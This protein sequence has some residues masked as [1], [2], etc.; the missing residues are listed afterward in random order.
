MV[1]KIRNTFRNGDHKTKVYLGIALC[2]IAATI[3]CVIAAAFLKSFVVL[4]G[5]AVFLLISFFVFRGVSFSVLHGNGNGQ[6]SD[7]FDRI[8]KEGSNRPIRKQKKSEQEKE[9]EEEEE[10]KTSPREEPEEESQGGISKNMTE[11][12]LKLLFIKFKVKQEH[13]PVVIDLCVSERIRQC[14]GF[15]WMA[16]GKLKVLLL[17]EKP[18][19][20][21]RAAGRL[22]ELSVERGAAVRAASEYSE[23]RQTDLLKKVFTP[24]LPHYHKKTIGGRTI[25]L[26]NLYLLDQD[27]KFSSGSVKSLMKL[28]PLKVLI[29]LRGKEEQV[30]AYYKELYQCSF[31]WQDAVYTFDEYRKMVEKIITDMASAEISYQDFDQNLSG[32]IRDGLL[33]EEFRTFAYT[34]R[35]QQKEEKNAPVKKKK[36]RE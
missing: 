4:S 25:L 9:K 20:I 28:L 26:K 8:G 34:K 29:P 14:P 32:M 6:I 11:E 16:D 36:K 3:L 15:A 1:K 7:S 17:E 19:L 18:R 23:L 27:I 22:K 13:V 21:E 33:P 5:A 30:S 10:A 31:L 2:L 12:K 35:E 24:F